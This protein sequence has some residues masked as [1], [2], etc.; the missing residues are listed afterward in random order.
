MA[1]KQKRT[2]SYKVGSGN[3]TIKVALDV[4]LGQLGAVK[5]SLDKKT[6]VIAA[7]PMGQQTVGP[8]KDIVDKLLILETMVSDVSIMTNKMSVVI[9]LTGG[10]SSK[11]ITTVGEVTDEGDSILF[12]T[13]VLFRE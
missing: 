9:Q 2:D 8:A 13:F 7:A 6:L 3:A 10:P 12:E 5:M 1:K 4:G 11:T